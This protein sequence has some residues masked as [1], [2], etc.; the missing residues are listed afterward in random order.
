[1]HFRR[2]TPGKGARRFVIWPQPML[3]MA[4][5]EILENGEAVPQHARAS[6]ERW[7]LP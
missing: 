6:L 7:H 5:G 3:G 1:M 4:L 2:N